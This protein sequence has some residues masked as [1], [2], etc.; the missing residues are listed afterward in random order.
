MVRETLF[1]DGFNDDL[2][3]ILNGGLF[4]SIEAMAREE[5]HG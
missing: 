4:E 2:D 3:G 1:E 5:A